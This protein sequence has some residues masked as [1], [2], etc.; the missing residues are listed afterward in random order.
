MPRCCN[1]S[2]VILSGPADFIFLKILKASS[3]SLIL[4]GLFICCSMRVCLFHLSTHFLLPIRRDSYITDLFIV[5]CKAVCS[6]LSC[7]P[8]FTLLDTNGS[9][10]SIFIIHSFSQLSKLVSILVKV[11][12][13]CLLSLSLSLIPPPA[14]PGSLYVGFLIPSTR[15]LVGDIVFNSWVVLHPFSCS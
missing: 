4:K 6:F 7:H 3:S 5:I 9:R 1:I 2:F 11:E 10:L 15:G 8:F 14:F 13:F 12:T